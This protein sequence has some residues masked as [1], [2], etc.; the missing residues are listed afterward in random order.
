M[1][2]TLFKLLLACFFVVVTSL[3]LTGFE[4]IHWMF[5]GSGLVA[6]I[7]QKIYQQLGDIHCDKRSIEVKRDSDGMM[8]Y[9]CGS[10][11]LLSKGDRSP[12]LTKAWPEIKR[13]QKDGGFP[14]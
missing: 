12:A 4:R 7:P 2:K 13:L 1:L 10:Y 6:V 3:F 11:W 5:S 9:R 14:S 8:R